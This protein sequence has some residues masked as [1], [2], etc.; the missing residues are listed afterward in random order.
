MQIMHQTQTTKMLIT[1]AMHQ[2][3]TTRMQTTRM[4]IMHQ[5]QT[6]KMQAM[7]QIETQIIQVTITNREKG[8]D[9]FGSFFRFLTV[10]FVPLNIENIG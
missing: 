10:P 6:I 8:P 4:Q 5:M 1:Q 2:M 9:I 3:R 7:R